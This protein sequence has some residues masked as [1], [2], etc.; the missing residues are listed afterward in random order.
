MKATSGTTSS[1][2]TT[3]PLPTPIGGIA[4]LIGASAGLPPRTKT[5][6]TTEA[7]SYVTNCSF[8]GTIISESVAANVYVGGLVG[9]NRTGE[10]SGCYASADVKGGYAG[11]LLGYNDSL[12][13]RSFATGKSH[14]QPRLS[15]NRGRA[16]SLQRHKRQ[17]YPPLLGGHGIRKDG[18]RPYRRKYVQFPHG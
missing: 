2:A 3:P 8:Q 4:G 6:E 9:F 16:Y 7:V 1:E 5:P 12:V 17:C 13:T 11:G 10:I 14:G 18:G 15:C